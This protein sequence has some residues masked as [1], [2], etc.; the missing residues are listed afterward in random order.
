LTFV[1]KNWPNDP[2]IGYKS[3]FSLVDFIENDVNLEK[4]LLNVF[5]GTFERDEIMEL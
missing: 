5:E 4:I 2:R 3:P 1:I